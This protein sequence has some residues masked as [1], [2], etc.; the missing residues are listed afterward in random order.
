M[1][2]ATWTIVLGPNIQVKDDRGNITDLGML[3][4]TLSYGQKNGTPQL[5]SDGLLD[6]GNI[7]KTDTAGFSG[8]DG[9]TTLG[10][11]I[12]DLKKKSIVPIIP[13]EVDAG[14]GTLLF[15]DSSQCVYYT[16]TPSGDTTLSLAGGKPGEVKDL[17]LDITMPNVDTNFKFVLPT[18]CTWGPGGPPDIPMAANSRMIIHFKAVGTSYLGGV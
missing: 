1:S 2:Q 8:Y 14:T 13:L 5:N 18:N 17:Y 4:T 9:Q 7:V 3:L 6:A 12:S 10:G 11:V 16:Y 15:S